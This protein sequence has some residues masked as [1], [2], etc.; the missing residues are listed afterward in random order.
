[1]NVA[2]DGEAAATAAFFP[3]GCLGRFGGLSLSGR[4]RGAAGALARDFALAARPLA[5]DFAAAARFDVA[6]SGPAGDGCVSGVASFGPDG[7][8][9]FRGAIVFSTLTKVMFR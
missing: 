6:L 9:R 1:M 2:I 7:A 3:R 8:G 4:G 5:R